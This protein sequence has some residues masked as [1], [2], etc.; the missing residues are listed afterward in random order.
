MSIN[1]H[2]S[3]KDNFLK[4]KHM[5]CI[6][7]FLITLVLFLIYMSWNSSSDDTEFCGCNSQ[8][9]I[10]T[11]KEGIHNKDCSKYTSPALRS[12]CEH[13]KE[14]IQY[15][16]RTKQ[17]E[18]LQYATKTKQPEYLQ[19]ATRTKNS[20]VS[21]QFNVMKTKT[22]NKAIPTKTMEGFVSGR[23]REGFSNDFIQP[24]KMKSSSSAQN[25]SPFFGPINL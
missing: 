11:R 17:P 14:G 7:V 25:N 13:G 12:M 5:T 4:S 2:S 16:T 3:T 10:K 21:E 9:G 8:E 6:L 15:A 23:G 22:V 19:Y 1:S 24:Q 18:Y 20:G